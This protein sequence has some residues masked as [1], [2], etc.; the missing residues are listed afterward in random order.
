MHRCPPD[1]QER[2]EPGEDRPEVVH[3]VEHL[4]GD[5]QVEPLAGGRRLRR[6]VEVPDARAF[7]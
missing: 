2:G 5:R 4:D 3:V 1:V 7:G 6:Q